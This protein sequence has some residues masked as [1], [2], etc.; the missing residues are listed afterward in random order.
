MR[1]YFV[2]KQITN[3][4]ETLYAALNGLSQTHKTLGRFCSVPVSILDVGLDTLKSPLG[5]IEYVA[6]TAINLI[7]AAF[8]KN[9]KLKDVLAYTNW[10]SND[11]FCSEE[12]RFT[13][14]DVLVSTEHTLIA[15][16]NLP[17]KLVVA[18]PK[19]IFQFFAIIINPEKV[20]SISLEKPVFK[21]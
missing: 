20:Q 17:V 18:A 6:M 2:T 12:A 3:L 8:F 11:F 16:A 10:T 1:T 19:I 14:K 5:V 21:A 4:Q 13:L 7:G 9:V 15:A